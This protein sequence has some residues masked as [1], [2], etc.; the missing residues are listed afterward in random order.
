MNGSRVS[1]LMK[2][3]MRHLKGYELNYIERDYVIDEVFKCV[4]GFYHNKLHFEEKYCTFRLKEYKH[5]QNIDEGRINK[6][7]IIAQV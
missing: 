7:K 6:G 4:L 5:S 1:K 2:G 3:K